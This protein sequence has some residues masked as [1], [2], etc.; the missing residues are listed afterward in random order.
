MKIPG[1]R[2]TQDEAG[3]WWYLHGPKRQRIRV[4]A[5]VCP[6]CGEEFVPAYRS[7]YQMPIHCSRTCGVRAAYKDPSRDKYEGDKHWKWNGGKTINRNGY[8]MRHA[9]D[10]PDVQGTKRTYVLEH[11]LVMEQKLGRRL[12]RGEYVHHINGIRT[13][14]RPENLELWR[15]AQPPGQRAHEQ[16]HCP[17]CTCFMHKRE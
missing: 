1:D 13:D 3:Q 10:H 16:Q 15:K 6:E 7:K 14:N 4:Y 8:V 11:R 2:F 17:T 12:L 9:P 5:R